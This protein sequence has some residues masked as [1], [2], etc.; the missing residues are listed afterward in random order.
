MTIT[1]AKNYTECTSEEDLYVFALGYEH[2]SYFLYDLIQKKFST[3][4]PIVFVFDDYMNYPDTVAKV[5][6][7]EHM[8]IPFYVENYRDSNKVQEKIL[9]VVN[10][11][12]AQ[13]DSVTIHIDYSSMP[14]SWYCKLPMSVALHIEDFEFMVSKLCDTTNELLPAGDVILIPDGPKPLIFA[15]S[16]VPNLVRKHGITCLHITRNNEHFEAVDVIATGTVHGFLV[17]VD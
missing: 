17:Q 7:L 4:K 11:Y 10:D 1:N 12:I 8:E 14:R 5:R 9:A 16:L 2:R 15:L 3:I 13:R 6:E